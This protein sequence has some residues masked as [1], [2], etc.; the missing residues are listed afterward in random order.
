VFSTGEWLLITAD[1]AIAS[2][3]ISASVA[4]LYLSL[5]LD[6]DASVITE[7]TL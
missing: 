7:L 3:I 5:V 1:V 2:Q 6:L 4:T